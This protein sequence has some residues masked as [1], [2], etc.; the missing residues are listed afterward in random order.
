MSETND[1]TIV[2]YTARTIPVQ[3]AVNTW[4]YLQKASFGLPI[5]IEE[6]DPNIAP[7]HLGIYRQALAGAKKAKTK[8]IALCEDDVL[9]SPEHFKYR[10]SPDKFAYN[11][12]FWNIHTWA[13]PIF[14]QKLGGR[15]NLSQLICER[16]LFIKAME[17]RFTKHGG[18]VDISIFAEPSKYEKN[19]GVTIREWEA[20]TT[21]PPNVVFSHQTAL[22]Y[23][24]L[25][26]RKK[27]GEIRSIEIPYWHTAKEIQGLYE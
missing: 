8:Y 19:L 6:K 2:Y 22:S 3:F 1:L 24:N 27:L 20:F 14:T 5:I 17:E 12:N 7:S 25:G 15:R 13:E 18:D 26:K 16:N 11:M 4:E 9:Y 21:N 10:P 23:Q